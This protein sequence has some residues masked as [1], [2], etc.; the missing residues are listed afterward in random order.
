M[1]SISLPRFDLLIAIAVFAIAITWSVVG[2]RKADAAGTSAAFISHLAEVDA[3]YVWNSSTGTLQYELSSTLRFLKK[4]VG[5][6]GFEPW[7]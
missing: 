7:T 6:Q 4:M 5:V 1:K 3:S 2:A